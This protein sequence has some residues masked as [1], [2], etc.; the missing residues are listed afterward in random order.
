MTTVILVRHGQTE[1]NRVERF[2]GRYDVPLNAAGLA[3]A[4][5][6]ARAIAARWQASAVYAS[7]LSRAM[8]TAEP[9]ARA[10]SV[11]PQAHPGLIDIDFGAWQG[12]T[13]EEARAGWPGLVEAWYRGGPD[14]SS[15][16]GESLATVGERAVDALRQLAARHAEQAIVAV[17]H[18]MVNRALLVCAMGLPWDRFWRIGQDNGAINVLQVRGDAFTMAQWNDTCHLLTG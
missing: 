11:E 6:A 14:M 8:A 10:L 5:A 18:T 9:I 15:P 2:R 3:Q 1:W 7:P 17:S 16:G 12:L 4:Q 13:P